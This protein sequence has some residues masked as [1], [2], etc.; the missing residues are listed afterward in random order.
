MRKLSRDKLNQKTK[1][2]PMQN[3]P[4]EFAVYPFVVNPFDEN[5]EAKTPTQAWN[6]F[7]PAC[8]AALGHMR[9]HP[10]DVAVVIDMR[11]GEVWQPDWIK[12]HVGFALDL[13]DA[14]P[15]SDFIEP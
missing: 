11:T 10:P 3:I 5:G 2:K 12:S 7:E 9:N 14:V 15:L 6:S 1:L 13:L 8:L 4:S